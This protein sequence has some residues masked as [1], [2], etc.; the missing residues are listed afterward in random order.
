M[1]TILKKERLNDLVDFMR[2]DAPMV[3]RNAKPGHFIILRVDA[4]GERIPLTIAGHDATSVDII[5]QKMG[6]STERLG[7]KEAGDS[8]EDFVGP[9]GKAAHIRN[10]TSVIG[11]AGGVGAA[12]LLPQ[13][14]AYKEQGAYVRVIIGAKNKDLLI[15][16]SQYEAFVDELY[17]TTDDGSMGEKGMVTAPLERLLKE[18][19]AEHVVAIGP[20]IMMK[21]AAQTA[22]TYERSVDVSLN[23]IM[24]DGTGMCGN[25]R[26]TVDGKTR[27]ACIDG[28]DFDGSNVD[29]DGL[30]KRQ[31]YYS[32]E[33]H[34]CKIKLGYHGE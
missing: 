2:I 32:D 6:Y 13:M 8:V 30:M 23:P 25:C 10:K 5:Y 28:P 15:L 4:D 3:A 20:V 1:Y 12:P 33:E 9:L 26:V 7:Q 17:I 24:I 16:K 29:F 19:V 14:K 27:F 22:K 11:V 31:A 18:T 21:F 34:T